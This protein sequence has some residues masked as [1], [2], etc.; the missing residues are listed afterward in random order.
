MGAFKPYK[1]SF[2]AGLSILSLCFSLPIHN[3]GEQATLQG[4]PE[5][6]VS[7]TQWKAGELKHKEMTHGL[8]ESNA[9]FTDLN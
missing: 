8:T 5:T 1:K 2:A 4:T 9:T 3:S 7:I 6:L